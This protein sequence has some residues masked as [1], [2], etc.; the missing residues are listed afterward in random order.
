MSIREDEVGRKPKPGRVSHKRGPLS[1]LAIELV[2]DDP[3][4]TN[5]RL[6]RRWALRVEDDPDLLEAAL[7]AQGDHEIVL[8]RNYLDKGS[9]G[10]KRKADDKEERLGKKMVL[11]LG[12]QLLGFVAENGKPIRDLTGDEL[13]ELETNNA[14]RARLYRE[15][16]RKVKGQ[17]RVGDLGEEQM[18][19]I[20]NRIGD[21]DAYGKLFR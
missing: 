1:E 12:E 7:T 5:S 18:R 15:L 13:V 14:A 19:A 6:I 9:T 10:G 4:A 17:S 20:L 8:A 21:V 3:K 11:K 2:K 16:S